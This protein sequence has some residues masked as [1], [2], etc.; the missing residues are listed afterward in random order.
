MSFKA[1]LNIDGF[2]E[3]P[4]IECDFGFY[5]ETDFTGKPSAR[6]SGGV[7][8]LLIQSIPLDGLLGWMISST[9]RKNGKIIFY[10]RD[11]ESAMKT[12]DFKD[13]VC[14]KYHEYFKHDT[15]MPMTTAITISARVI[16][17]GVPTFTRNW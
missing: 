16:K 4:V 8:N 11:N 2:P 6:P 7:V 3:I 14:I 10:K 12:V 15:K 13:A 5:Q 17:V 9:E 1:I